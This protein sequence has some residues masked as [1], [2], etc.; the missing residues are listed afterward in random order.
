MGSRSDSF[1]RRILRMM[2]S[3]TAILIAFASAAST[4][5]ASDPLPPVRAALPQQYETIPD[6]TPLTLRFASVVLGA[7]RLFHRTGS[8][9]GENINLV[10]ATEVRVNNRVVI[11]KGALAHAT[12]A[13]SYWDTGQYASQHIGIRLDW[14]K[15]VTGTI[16]PIRGLPSGVPSDFD[17][18][19][20]SSDRGIEVRP[21]DLKRD[22]KDVFTLHIFARALHQKMW[23]PVGARIAVYTDR[24]RL[25][26]LSEVVAAQ[27]RFPAR[28]PDTFVTIYRSKGDA[29]V[30][31]WVL[32][33]GKKLSHMSEHEYLT[34]TVPPGV[35]VMSA[36]P[37]KKETTFTADA[38]Q[39]CFVKLQG[40]G[41]SWE[42]KVVDV[43]QADDEMADAVP[44]K[45]DPTFSLAEKPK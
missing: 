13:Y 9:K 16:I 30:V 3:C 38:G 29:E 4:Q 18:D 27:Q 5:Q 34:M 40:K 14:V 45:Q 8:H 42:I 15:S 39:D 20:F 11:E 22:M 26:E 2:T 12:V 6:G 1:S 7:P 41:T 23:I 25:L 35:Y 24:A 28:S 36:D 21:A 44:A 37:G 32:L 17:A 31:P 10:A 19:I 33:S 43:V